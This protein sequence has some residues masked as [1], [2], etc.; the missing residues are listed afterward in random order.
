MAADVAHATQGR[1]V[2]QN[3]HLSGVSFDSRT[4]RPGQL[5]V[6][7]V[8][9]R[10]G[11][12]FISAARTGG[13]GAYLTAHEPEGGTAIV[14]DDTVAALGRLARWARHRLSTHVAGRVVGITGSVGKTSTKDLVATALGASMSTAA[15]ER[16]LNNDLGVPVTILNA[17][18][19]VAAL[20]LEMGMR[21]EG[22]IDRLCRIA[23]PS[24]GVVTAVAAAH[25]SRVG[26]ID[27]VARA[28]SE[29][30]RALPDD[31]VAVLNADD[32]RVAAMR[33]LTRARVVTYGRSVDADIR[34]VEVT[35]DDRAHP[36]ARY[37]GVWGER[38]V[39]LPVPGAH[40]A[41][42]AAAALAVCIACGADTARAAD[43]M[44]RVVMSGM[45]MQE[46]RTRAGAV[47][48]DD[49]YNANPASVAA[50]L[51]ALAAVRAKRR[52][53]IL[54][55]M[56]ELADSAAEHRAIAELADSLGIEM[57]VVDAPDYGCRVVSIGDAEEVVAQLTSDDAV[58]VKGSRV[59]G[60]DQLVRRCCD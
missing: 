24:V 21:G 38:V 31:G 27:G 4:L 50:A 56:A 19:S 58:L 28:K 54:G 40:M 30:V 49:S 9:G 12:E 1:L 33:D 53:A 16:S 3:A 57:C 15:S 25:T 32:R 47:L 35:L 29:L 14:V 26:G 41:H 55:V 2:G 59:A 7:V 22:E 5:F 17:P 48:I 23:E 42:N 51:H 10:D 43:A 11:H 39:T 34:I 44:S 20:V 13:A 36:T 52:V 18:D 37:V 45:R 6:P 60:L 46:R 8:A